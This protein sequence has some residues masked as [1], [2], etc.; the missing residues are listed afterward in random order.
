MG[1]GGGVGGRRAARVCEWGGGKGWRGG[2]GWGCPR[3]LGE[4]ADVIK[5]LCWAV[6]F[7]LVSKGRGLGEEHQGER[8]YVGCVGCLLVRWGG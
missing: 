4:A 7:H 3:D 1:W 8:V 5:V 2:K 6:G